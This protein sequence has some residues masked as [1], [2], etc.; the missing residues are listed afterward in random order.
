MATPAA[1]PAL[2]PV[3]DAR[4]KLRTSDFFALCMAMLCEISYFGE[5]SGDEAKRQIRAAVPKAPTPPST[6]PGAWRL[7]WG[8]QVDQNNANLMFAAEFM[9]TTQNPAVPVFTSI[10]IRGTN[11]QST[12]WGILKQLIEDLDAEDQVNFPTDD[13]TAAP[14][15]A[16]AAGKRPK[17]A[18]GTAIGFRTLRDMTDESGRTVQQYVADFLQQNQGAPVAVTGHSLGGCQT[19]VMA[20]HLALAVPGAV[21]VPNS[22]AA[23]SAG[24]QDFIDLYQQQCP[25]APRWFNDFDLVPM[26]YAGLKGIR[27]L[28]SM[29]S[30]PASLLVKAAVEALKIL[31]DMEGASYA[32]ESFGQS[33]DLRGVCRPP[34]SD[35]LAGF[36]TQQA[37]KD[38]E[39]ALIRIIEKLPVSKLPDLAKALQGEIPGNAFLQ[40]MAQSPAIVLATGLLDKELHAL[41]D[42]TRGNL[43]VWV[44]ELLFQHSLGTGYWEAVKGST[45]VA[46][47]DPPSQAAVATS[48]G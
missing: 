2:T 33:R 5:T 30:V 13:S 37:A 46:P 48:G 22:F 38:L 29:C 11:L 25:F 14:F 8:P 47:I 34:S 20:L 40:K 3:E 15:A 18:S 16:H 24:N 21:I 6:V 23:P 42:H 7:G 45:G 43:L 27:N 28:W 26:A 12:P 36:D 9:D 31:L 1:G 19:T 39:G 32:Q 35:L 4:N 41:A 44:Q 10:A 17:I